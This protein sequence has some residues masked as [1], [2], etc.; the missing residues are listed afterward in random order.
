MIKK[1]GTQSRVVG[2]GGS[3][4]REMMVN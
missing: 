3:P 4:K 1:H 2:A